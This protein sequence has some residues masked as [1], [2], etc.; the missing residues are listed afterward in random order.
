VCIY[1]CGFRACRPLTISSALDQPIAALIFCVR[2]HTHTHLSMGEIDKHTHTHPPPHHH[3]GALKLPAQLHILLKGHT[4]T[5]THTHTMSPERGRA[6][7][8]DGCVTVWGHGERRIYSSADGRFL[9]ADRTQPMP[10]TGLFTGYIHRRLHV[11][12][13]TLHYA[14]VTLKYCHPV[15]WSSWWET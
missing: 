14:T 4:H 13:E 11:N 6:R 3:W 5:H 12:S 8:R 15:K 10:V 9:S 7:G 1:V 2:G